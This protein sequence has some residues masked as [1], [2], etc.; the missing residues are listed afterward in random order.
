MPELMGAVVGPVPLVSSQLLPSCWNLGEQ[1][2]EDSHCSR[3]R[4]QARK[5]RGCF[6][7]CTGRLK[8]GGGVCAGGPVL[9]PVVGLAAISDRGCGR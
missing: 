4:V 5:P 8:G 3:E 2:S 7:E 6:S 9:S 1:D